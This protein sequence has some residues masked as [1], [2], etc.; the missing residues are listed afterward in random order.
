MT[1]P[2]KRLGREGW[3]F[4]I[5]QW[6]AFG[7]TQIEYCAQKGINSKYFSVWK[8]KLNPKANTSHSPKFIPVDV[9]PDEQPKIDSWIIKVELSNGV[10]IHVPAGLP[11]AETH[12]LLSTLMDLAC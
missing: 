2:K 12:K 1:T 6:R 4:H 5:D 3:Q 10:S 9:A 11:K 7:L 8:S